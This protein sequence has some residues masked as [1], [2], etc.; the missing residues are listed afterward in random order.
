MRAFA[1]IHQATAG[2]RL[3]GGLAAVALLATGC[4]EIAENLVEEGVEKAIEADSGEDIEL[5]FDGEDGLTIETE[6]GSLRVD[7]DG[8]F[9]IEDADGE[10]VTGETTD[11]GYTVSDEDGNAVIDF[12]EDGG[13][14]TA[15]SEDGSF[16]AGPGV[17]A[18]WPGS[19]PEPSGLADVTGSTIV[20][21]GQ[22][23]MSASG[24]PSEGTTEYFESYASSLE[25]DGYERTSYFES[26]GLRQGNYENGDYIISLVGDEG[27]S[28][29]GI[30]LMSTQG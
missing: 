26:D 16:T 7:E 11:D 25:S 14:V 8:S 18:D 21:D 23:V 19:V 10:V 22:V 24:T 6:D 1:Q 15:E 2:R 13:V 4:G 27:S 3:I 12:D 30:T 9:V 28:T 20:S 17:P 29:I 5:D